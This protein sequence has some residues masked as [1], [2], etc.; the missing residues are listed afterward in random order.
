MSFVSNNKINGIQ[1]R[2][3]KDGPTFKKMLREKRVKSYNSSDLTNECFLNE[4]TI[5]D[6][7]S[8]TN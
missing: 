8:Q 1:K 6:Y 5:C 3:Y 2:D 7:L 4:F